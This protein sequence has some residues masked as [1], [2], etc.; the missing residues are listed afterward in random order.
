MTSAGRRPAPILRLVL[1]VAAIQMRGM[2]SESGATRGDEPASRVRRPVALALSGGGSSLLVANGR[3]GTI[4]VID[5]RSGRRIA[6][7]QVAR[8]LSD[9]VPLPDG[10][11][12]AAIDP[13]AGDLLL[14]EH[15]AERL[16]VRS[17]LSLGPDPIRVAILPG[18]KAAATSRW[19]RRLMIVDIELGREENALTLRRSI[20]LPFAPGEVLPLREG[21]VLLVADAFGGKLA[22]VDPVRGTIVSVREIPGHNLRGLTLTHDGSTVILARQLSS[23]LAT[24]SFD[25]VH[26]GDLMK[27]QVLRLRSDAILD[28]GTSPL[29]G[30]SARDL[31]VVGHA[32]GDPEDLAI[33]PKGRTVVAL[34]GVGEVAIFDD[35]AS[36]VA[37]VAAGTRPFS[38][39]LSPNGELACVADIEEDA[40]SIVPLG[41]GPARVVSLGP[42]PKPTAIERG[43]RLFNSAVLSHHGWMS[44]R[45]CHA[46]GHTGGFPADTFG[47]KSYGTPKL[48]PSLLGVGA[49]GPWGWLGSFNT[50]EDQI[51][52]SVETTLRGKPLKDEGVAD[53][54]AYLRSLRPPP[55][56]VIARESSDRGAAV[57]RAKKCANC[58]AGEALTADGVRDVGLLDEAGHREFNPPSLRGVGQRTRFLHDG[59]AGSLEAVFSDHVH[60]PGASL[61]DSELRDLLAYLQSL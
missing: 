35:G 26:W 8:A 49:S 50:L 16:A 61:T 17:R 21:K 28:P 19:S 23:R 15:R 31:D 27:N 52:S 59:R 51:R 53:L 30:S 10:V 43:E 40:V 56:L 38:V 12:F 45:S 41:G 5:I 20:D 22:V 37:R 34:A 9:L 47:D 54:A 42:R 6:E 3:S 36:S 13:D 24:S 4:S 29:R 55:P 1:I 14:L 11:R 44:C 25:D 48:V 60:P 18:G 33:D 57:F 2:I 7:H 39:V 46:E 32:A 58:H